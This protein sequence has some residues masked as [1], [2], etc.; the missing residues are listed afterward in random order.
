MY[1]EGSDKLW[2]WFGLGRATFCVMPRVLMHEMPDAWQSKMADLLREYDATFATHRL[3]D[4]KVQ[5]V[6]PDNKFTKWPY[7][8]LNYRY[9]DQDEIAA[10][11]EKPCEECGKL[12]H[13]CPCVDAIASRANT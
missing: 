1:G 7:W 6:G 11:R 8:L 2:T 13:E 9:P 12:D 5:A 4:C 3:P 10:L